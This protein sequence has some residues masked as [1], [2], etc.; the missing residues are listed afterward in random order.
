MEMSVFGWD[1]VNEG[2][3]QQDAG[4]IPQ[5]SFTLSGPV[6]KPDPRRV[7][8][9]GD[10]AHIGLA[11][12]YFVPHYVV[13]QIKVVGDM[14]ANLRAEPSEESEIVYDLSPLQRFELLDAEGGWAWGCLGI[15]GPVG[16]V[17]IE[18]LE[19]PSP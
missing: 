15:D 9:H 13:P 19:D 7:P 17:R 5:G 8:V 12:R 10:L 3:A 6:G 14:G 16:Y 11:G 4:G 18:E 2:M 1:R